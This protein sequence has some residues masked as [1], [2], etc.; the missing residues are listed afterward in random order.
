MDPDRRGADATRAVSPGV[1]IPHESLLPVLAG[2]RDLVVRETQVPPPSLGDVVLGTVTVVVDLVRTALGRGDAPRST[3]LDAGFELA[4]RGWTLASRGA[5]ALAQIG[6]PV[7]QVVAN[8]PLVP[9]AWRPGTLARQSAEAWR[10]RS[11]ITVAAAASVRD[12]VVPPLV[13]SAMAPL[14]L[15]DIVL[16]RVELGRVVNAALD[17]VDLTDIV[18]ERV[19]LERIVEAVLERIDLDAVARERMDLM[20]LAQYIVDGIDLPEIIRQSTG[21]MASETVRTVRL[22]SIDADEAVQRVVDR[23]LLW[24]K[25]RSVQAP[26]SADPEP[27]A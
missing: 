25:G 15:T 27:G 2:R 24:R 9:V 11:P 16:D 19:D 20:G 22:Q 5:T 8:P 26:D 18:L 1:A 23:L 3:A 12:R 4:W 6:Q 14:D 13:E 7:A 10:D 17:Q 21:S